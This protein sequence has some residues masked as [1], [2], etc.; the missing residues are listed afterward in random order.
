M[1]RL[2]T[3]LKQQ[4]WHPNFLSSLGLIR[5]V[6]QCFSI[7]FDVLVGG[8]GLKNHTNPL[9]SGTLFLRYGYKINN[10]TD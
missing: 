1:E 10:Y 3:V 5:D 2:S 4:T 9:S 8:G 7:Y 6:N